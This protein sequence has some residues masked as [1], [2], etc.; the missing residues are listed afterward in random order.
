MCFFCDPALLVLVIF[1]KEICSQAHKGCTREFPWQ[2]DTDVRLGTH[3]GM[4]LP[5]D[6]EVN[7]GDSGWNSMP[8]LGALDIQTNQGK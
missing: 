6:G 4:R 7:R 1:P 3:L 5:G 8:Q 2:C